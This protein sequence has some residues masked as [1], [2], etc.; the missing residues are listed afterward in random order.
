MRRDIP[1]E[2][3]RWP[4]KLTPEEGEKVSGERTCFLYRKMG[5]MAQECTE[6]RLPNAA[7]Q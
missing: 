5:H 4:S 1:V 3:R 6:Q 2:R 7:R